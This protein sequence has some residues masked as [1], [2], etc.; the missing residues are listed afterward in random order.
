MSRWAHNRYDGDFVNGIYHGFGTFKWE[1]NASYQG[2]W[3][4]GKRHGAGIYTSGDGLHIYDG[5]W[6]NDVKHG[7]GFQQL[8]DGRTFEGTFTEGLAGSGVL[9]L[10][11]D[12]AVCC[13]W[14]HG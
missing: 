11:G 6:Q 13:A 3:K 7:H 8:P 2:I 5:D 10:Q 4:D 12:T 9:T 1:D 14:R